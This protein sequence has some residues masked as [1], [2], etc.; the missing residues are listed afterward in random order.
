MDRRVV[1]GG[2]VVD[3]RLRI[4]AIG[5]VGERVARGRVARGGW[6]R[7]EWRRWRV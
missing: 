4:V 5:W 3:R 6:V 2:R 1:R 7:R